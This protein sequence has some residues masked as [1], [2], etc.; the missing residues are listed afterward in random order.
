MTEPMRIPEITEQ[1]AA[2]LAEA[3]RMAF[4]NAEADA[5]FDAS[6]AEASRYEQERE[7]EQSPR[8][9]QGELPLNGEEQP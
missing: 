8:A 2:D 1:E 9:V 6:M 4:G 7:R 5:F 3:C